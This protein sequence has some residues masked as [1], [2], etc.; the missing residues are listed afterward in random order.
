MS[1]QKLT[2]YLTSSRGTRRRRTRGRKARRWRKGVSQKRS[3]ER[4]EGKEEWVVVRRGAAIGWKE[5]RVDQ[6]T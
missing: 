6:V 2:T 3:R 4:K 1:R 5:G